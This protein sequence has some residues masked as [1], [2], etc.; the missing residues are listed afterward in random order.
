MYTSGEIACKDKVGRLTKDSKEGAGCGSSLGACG[1]AG[2]VTLVNGVQAGYDNCLMR[3]CESIIVWN[4]W[5]AVLEPG[6]RG[7]RV[8]SG[9]TVEN[10]GVSLTGQHGGRQRHC[11]GNWR[12][13]E[14][15]CMGRQVSQV[16]LYHGVYS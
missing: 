10:E 6:E 5:L 8:A 9:L 12:A 1:Q 13:I 4:Q 2:V 16:T 14:R 15:G 11:W 3:D 7:R